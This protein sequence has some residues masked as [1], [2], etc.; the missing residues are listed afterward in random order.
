MPTP[1]IGKICRRNIWR[2]LASFSDASKSEFAVI[3]PA[4]A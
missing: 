4:P 1:E 3:P 2:R